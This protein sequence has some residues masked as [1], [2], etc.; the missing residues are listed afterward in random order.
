VYTIFAA[1]VF[2]V[3]LL[4]LTGF[5]VL[6]IARIVVGNFRFYNMNDYTAVIHNPAMWYGGLGIPLILLPFISSVTIFALA[7][8]AGYALMYGSLFAG[9]RA[10]IRRHYP[11]VI[12]SSAWKLKLQFLGNHRECKP[13]WVSTRMKGE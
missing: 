4:V 5:T 11:C 10:L 12:F 13:R 8:I 1:S 9:V 7:V 3:A 2:A 6:A